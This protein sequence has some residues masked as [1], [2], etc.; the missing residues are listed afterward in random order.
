MTVPS[1]IYD[2][3]MI[4]P[5][6]MTQFCPMTEPEICAFSYILVDA[7]MRVLFPILHVLIKFYISSIARVK[8]KRKTHRAK[9][10]ELSVAMYLFPRVC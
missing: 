9:E 5:A 4:D 2:P 10:T 3:S 6:P 1:K 8:K 7:P